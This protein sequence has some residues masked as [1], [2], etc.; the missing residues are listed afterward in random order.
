MKKK[1]VGELGLVLLCAG[2][3][4]AV[5]APAQTDRSA[6]E[7][8]ISP[9]ELGQLSS[10]NAAQPLVYEKAGVEPEQKE[11]EALSDEQ[12]KFME[13]YPGKEWPVEDGALSAF[14][15]AVGYAESRGVCVGDKDI[16]GAGTTAWGYTLNVYYKNRR[17]TTI[18]LAS[19]FGCD[20]GPISGVRYYVSQVP[21]LQMP[22]LLI[23]LRHTTATAYSVACFDNTGWTDCYGPTNTTI[24][25]IGWYTFMFATPFEY[26]GIDN[27]E[28]DVSLGTLPEYNNSGQVWSFT[29]SGNRSLTAQSDTIG[30]PANWTCGT[31]NP[32]VTMRTGVPRMQFIFPP[33]NDGACCVDY[34]CVATTTEPDCLAMNGTWYGGET[35]PEFVCPPWND[36]CGAVTPVALTP[37]VPV[38]FTGNNLGATNDCGLFAGGQVWHA[39]TLPGVDSFFDVWLDY[40][41]TSPAFG[42]AWLNWA[43]GCPCTSA[44][45]AGTFDTT[46]CGDGNVT[47]KWSSLTSGT[48]YYPV[49]LDPASGAAGDYVINVVCTQAYCA[50]GATS[51]ADEM[52]K[53]VSFV[54]IYNLTTDCAK[55]SDFTDI[56][57]DVIAG[58]TY[59]IDLIIGDCEGTSCYSKR[60]SIFMDLNQ[61]YV[62][63]NPGE[64]VYYSGQ[65]TN[66]PCPDFPLSG[67]ITIPASATTGC[68]RMR[69]VVVETSSVE[70]PPCGT[71][72]W[73]ETEDYTV[74]ILPP[75]PEGACCFG[76]T[77]EAPLTEADCLA[78]EGVYKGDGTTC[79]PNPCIG[80]C[81]FMDGTCQEVLNLAE[82]AGLGGNYQGDGTDCDPNLCPQPGNN[83]DNPKPILLTAGALPYVDTDTTCGRG[84]NYADTCLGYYDGGEDILYE[85]IVPE[86][87]CVT[88]AV[89]GVLTYVGV[90]IDYSCPPG[91]TCLAFN[92]NSAGNPVIENLS[93]AAGTYYIMIDTWPSPPC[94]DFTMTIS[95]CPEPG[96]CCFSDGSCQELLPTPCATAGGIFQGDGTTCDPNPCQPTY[97]TAGSS[98]VNCDEYISRVE[99]GT[100]DNATGCSQ[101]G[102]YGDY[103]Y[104]STDVPYGIPMQITVT[105]GKPYTSDQC[106][107]WI[108]WNQ[109]LDFYDDGEGITMTGSP[110]VGPY[111]AT[112]LAPNDAL[113]GPARMRVRITYTGLLDPCGITTYGEVEDY[114]VNIVEVP[115]ACCQNDGTCTLELPS[116][117]FGY[118]GGP[119]TECAGEDCNLN[120]ADDFCDIASGYS[121]DCDGNG[122][123]DECQ[124]WCDCN[125][126][127][128]ADFCDLALGY[129]QDCNENGIPDECDVLPLCQAGAPCFPEVCSEDCQGDGIPDDCQLGS[130][131]IS[132]QIDDGSSENNWGLTNGGELCWLNHFNA[133]GPANVAG[134]SVCFGSPAY[135]GSAGVTPGGAVRIYVWSDP[136]QD[137]NP[138]D[139][140]FLG[141]GTGVVE[142][143]SIDTDVVQYV[144]FPAPIAVNGSFFAGASVNHPAGGYPVPADDNGWT[145]APDQGYLAY[146]SVP[147][148]PA[149]LTANPAIATRTAC[150]TSATFRR[151]ARVRIAAWTASRI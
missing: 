69:I 93:L 147:F 30:D 131:G 127:G 148:D 64:R 45:A 10:A 126:N 1:S 90:A 63:D 9:A 130:G 137:G 141:E 42:N 125:E 97:C 49:L 101:P 80:A 14:P 44:S 6:A 20:G 28:V 15:L 102:G 79:T 111:T 72:T 43:V 41:T 3:L 139:A 107:V 37:G 35:C 81:C 92:N 98:T 99:F 112:I 34:V 135:P 58:Q 143:G 104:L 123:P 24:T 48:Y 110:G 134:L 12:L 21:A 16:D 132:L 26:N 65:L 129:S 128:I 151:S 82:C 144:T 119:Y 70:P 75:P 50:S 150:P 66:T 100:I 84:N 122:I 8:A 85:V 108:D 78:A 46:T 146:N 124:P 74:C 4:L 11:L 149:N 106:K 96:A 27:L 39:I 136:N 121:E 89:D 29:G 22:N 87:L 36:N 2:L 133:G 25:Q 67:M 62:F 105:N 5:N 117:C 17:S 113:S 103:T 91:L 53:E 109:D 114:T 57:T 61:D 76:M 86:P 118:Y 138:A 38:Q 18:Y 116:E 115:G 83:C 88:I 40:C 77:C 71:Y 13:E 68:T 56:S 7:T 51:T 31:G 95:A 142:A 32:T 120:G 94:S 55:Y 23:R 73:G 47:I 60:V 140:V 19:E 145:G 59:P 52:L 54:D 33:P